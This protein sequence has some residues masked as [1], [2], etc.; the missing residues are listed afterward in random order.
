MNFASAEE[1]IRYIANFKV[2]YKTEL[3]RNWINTGRC[4]FDGDCAY[5]H[6]Q[7][8]LNT[9]RGCNNNYKTKKCK[10][11]HEITPGACN[12]GDKC[13]FIHDELQLPE[14]GINPYFP[15]QNYIAS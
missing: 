1:K 8:E 15:S 7:I 14:L 2:H 13:Q 10:K 11:W 4:E 9:R 3:C 6:G 5:A 12:Y